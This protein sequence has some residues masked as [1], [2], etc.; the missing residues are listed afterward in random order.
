MLP[1]SGGWPPEIDITE[2]TG[3][4]P[5]RVVMSLHWGPLGPGEYPWDIG[6]TAN[7]EYWGPDYTQDFHTFALEWWPGLL[8]WYIDDTVRFSVTRAQVPDETLYLILNTAV[9]GDWPGWPDGSTV[10]PQYH[11]IDYVRVSVPADPGFGVHELTDPSTAGAEADGTIG[12]TEYVALADGINDG[13]GDVLGENSTLHIDTSGDGRLNIGLDSHTLLSASGTGGV[14]IY[15]DST[16]GG[17]VTTAG[18][19]G[20]GGLSRRLTAGV[21]LGGDRAVLYFAPGF[22]ADRA[23]CLGPDLA[24]VY[25]IFGSTLVQLN[26]AEL[27]AATDL[28][29]GNDIAYHVDDGTHGGRMREFQVPLSYL[30]LSPL[31]EFLLVATLLDG[32]SAYRSNEFVGVAPGN[33]WDDLNPGTSNV[34]LKHG[35]FIRFRAAPAYGDLNVDGDVNVDDFTQFRVCYTGSGGGPAGPLCEAGDF[36]GDGDVDCNDYQG[37]RAAFFDSSGYW[38]AMSVSEFVAALLDP[39]SGEGDL[40]IADMDAS[41]HADGEDIQAYVQALLDG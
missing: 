14:V 24:M 35:D 29:G 34:V 6:Q 30:G 2:L 21:G 22:R 15:I 23:I 12:P 20:A 4:V 16:T 31:D 28:S 25:L 19:N 33:W 9:G 1:Q 39:A 18:L 10:L 7:T 17:V 8:T 37:F 41:G 38:P 13:F 36:D 27:G 40:C 5:W 26:G 3:D 32:D 11:L